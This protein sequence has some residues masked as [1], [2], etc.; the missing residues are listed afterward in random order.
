MRS[1]L[2]GVSA[3]LISG[4]LAIALLAFPQQHAGA[5]TIRFAKPAGL[6][7]G[8]CSSWATAC[9]LQ[10]AIALAV[11]GDQVWVARGTHKPTPTTDP[12]KS[13]HLKS[14]VAIYGGFS[15]SE[16]L[17][18]QRNWR[19][20]L[21]TLSG[22]LGV[23]GDIAD[24]S[25]HVV[26]A[27]GV[28]RSAVLDGFT[29]AAG[30]ANGADPNNQGGGLYNNAGNPT[31][32]NLKFIDNSA[33]NGGGMANTNGSPMLVRVIFSSNDAG[34][35]GGLYNYSYLSNPVLNNVVFAGNSAS[36]SGGG[37][38]SDSA[39]ATLT[40]VTFSSNTASSGGGMYGIDIGV[41]P[42]RNV[43]FYGNSAANGGGIYIAES[44]P[45]LTNVTFSGNTASTNGGAIY[46]TSTSGSPHLLDS[47]FW[48]DSSNEI[49]STVGSPIMS[50]EN[51]IVAGGCPSGAT[52]NSVSFGDPH[53]GLLQSN[54]GF[55]QTMAP[56]VGSAAI[57][58]AN[59][60]TCTNR[61][62]RGIARPQGD[63]CDM[64]A[65]E[66]RAMRFIS[67]AAYDGWVLESGQGSAVGGSHS[68]SLATLRVG[69]DASNRQYRAV[70]SFDTAGL[71]DVTS[72]VAAHLRA[73]YVGSL[74]DTSSLS[75]MRIDQ[76]APFLGAGPGLA[77]N[78]FESPEEWYP[79]DFGP[80]TGG[81]YAGYMNGLSTISDISRTGLTQFRLRF[82]TATDTNGAA[83]YVLFYSGDAATASNRPRLIIYFNP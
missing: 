45:A 69:D 6:N 32:R 78:D 10:R 40:S 73:R 22:D 83:D 75:Y 46:N 47:I 36:P 66:V 70:L 15:G 80:T 13:F 39:A 50:I 27:T 62:Q 35:G 79:S 65:Y 16:T 67:Q 42:L 57:D 60:G 64:G 71:P 8:S 20:N 14:G 28:S 52:C 41:T 74:G 81:W 31:L 58:A 49:Y 5:S 19:T 1:H 43:T 21:T 29:I 72:V 11:S 12:T 82:A 53:L 56:G 33:I 17:L 59:P 63:G 4:L 77:N 24:N 2:Y 44:S 61:D 23:I 9:K 3:R 30:N 18:S 51:S 76:R 55:T 34:A 37:M 68:A 25:Y 7:S 38:Y 54:G 48:G 26:Y